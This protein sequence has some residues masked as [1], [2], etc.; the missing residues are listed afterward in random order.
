MEQFMMVMGILVGL[1]GLGYVGLPLWAYLLAP[2]NLFFT[3]V[4]EG[5]AKVVM[6]GGKFQRVIIA[7]KGHY[8]NDNGDVVK[9]G[10][11]EKL[12]WFE[13]ISGAYWVGIPPFFRVHTYGFLW[14]TLSKEEVGGEI[15]EKPKQREEKEMDNVFIKDRVYLGYIFSAE[16][17]EGMPVDIR[18]LITLRVVNP[19]KALFLVHRWLEATLDLVSQSGRQ[20]VG[21]RTYQQLISK[22][23]ADPKK[24]FSGGISTLEN[25]ILKNYGVF[26]VKAEIHSVEPAGTAAEKYREASIRAY[27][28]E[29]IKNATITE[30]EGEARKNVLIGK[31]K[32]EAQQ[33][34]NDVYKKSPEATRA[35]YDAQVG[36]AQGIRSIAASIAQA[37]AGQG[38][39]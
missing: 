30:A 21:R 38:R 15:V 9:S 23:T 29:T 11:P 35:S 22:E 31:S 5:T 37:L 16:T 28:A 32:A 6:R 1:I 39:T 17:K 34:Q 10:D 33:F 20:Y 24:G 4:N 7:L 26:F 14:T 27:L 19:Y 18:Y 13:R 2:T 12:R 3:F 36:I 25:Q 8:L